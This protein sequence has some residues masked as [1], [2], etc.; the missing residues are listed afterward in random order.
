[1]KQI[2][3]TSQHLDKIIKDFAEKI[4]KQRFN[5]GTFEY[6]VSVDA[7]SSAGIQ[8]P[9]LKINPIAMLK[10]QALVDCTTDEISWHGLTKREGNTYTISDI[11][12]YPQTVT[13]AAVTTDE[14]EYGA[15]LMALDDEQFN[16]V[17]MQ[18]HSHVNFST[19]PSATDIEYYQ[20]IL[21]TLPKDDFYVFLIINKK[22]EHFATIYDLS[23]N[24]IYENK[25]IEI[26]YDLDID[27][28]QWAEEMRDKFVSKKIYTYDPKTA[29]MP[30]A[31]TPTLQEEKYWDNVARHYSSFEEY[32]N[33]RNPGRTQKQTKKGRV[34]NGPR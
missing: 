13:G 26:K 3:I 25:D 21:N 9:V 24:L 29:Q 33:F 15:W 7:V 10:M 28:T 19:S 32:Q 16:A 1:M 17:R 30:G 34:K 18:G 2:K 14:K 23:K 5:N 31:Y 8:K 27:P 4:K 12:V 20:N 22:R 11:I 6:K